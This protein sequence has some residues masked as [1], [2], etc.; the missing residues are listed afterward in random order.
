M[1]A[2]IDV[3]MPVLVREP[4]RKVP[5]A[6]FAMEAMRRCTN[7]PFRFVVTEYV[8]R[9]EEP[10]VDR[11]VLLDTDIYQV[12]S[13]PLSFVQQLNKGL[14]LCTADYV[15]HTADDIFVNPG[16]L[17][18][19][20]AC[21]KITDCGVATLASTDLPPPFS[22]KAKAIVEGIYGPH[23][24][25]RRCWE[26]LDKALMNTELGGAAKRFDPRYSGI[27]SDSDLI[28]AHYAAGLRSYRNHEVLIDHLNKATYNQL[29]TKEEQEQK[30]AEA[31]IAFQMKFRD[32]T[33]LMVFQNFVRGTLM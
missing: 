30:I 21:F 24:M 7:L 15:V 5:M 28:M 22:Q 12:L 8:M 2:T 27:F 3:L 4:K 9:G 25:F 17:E 1:D 20:L 16:W 33:P 14:E 32:H 11:S 19:M 13:S 29:F 6:R 26:R 10:M 23:M 18:A 31:S